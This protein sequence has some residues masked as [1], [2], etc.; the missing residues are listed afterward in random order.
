MLAE[1]E[2]AKLWDV[3]TAVSLSVAA[4][5]RDFTPATATPSLMVR[6]DPSS[7]VSPEH[8]EQLKTLGFEVR[9]VAGAG[10]SIWYGYFDAFMAALDGWI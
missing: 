1:L 9:S 6:A 10:H 2:A 7:C 8:A 4:A 3:R 5:G